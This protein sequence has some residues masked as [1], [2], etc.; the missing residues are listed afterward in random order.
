VVLSW[1]LTQA[2]TV[3][4][5]AGVDIGVQLAIDRGPYNVETDR[6]GGVGRSICRQW[7]ASRESCLPTEPRATV[8]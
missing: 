7:S 5:R 6:E 4:R 2:S 3:L 1:P 8:M